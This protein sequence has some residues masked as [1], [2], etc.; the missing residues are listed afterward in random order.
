MNAIEIDSIIIVYFL[1]LTS[2]KGVSSISINFPNETRNGS[3]TSSYSDRSRS[4]RQGS[5]TSEQS[6]VSGLSEYSDSDFVQASETRDAKS[7]V[8]VDQN[9]QKLQAQ[10]MNS[11]FTSGRALCNR[12]CSA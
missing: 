7:S 2:P 12:I 11:M 8:D 3:A 6:R 5:A 9:Q 1:G 10:K 4:T